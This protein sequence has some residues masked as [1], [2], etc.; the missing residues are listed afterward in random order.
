[1]TR[2]DDGRCQDEPDQLGSDADTEIMTTPE[3][4]GSLTSGNFAHL[5]EHEAAIDPFS[6][7]VSIRSPVHEDLTGLPSFEQFQPDRKAF[8]FTGNSFENSFGAARIESAM[9]GYEGSEQSTNQGKTSGTEEPKKDRSMPDSFSVT[10]NAAPQEI[11]IQADNTFRKG[12][13]SGPYDIGLTNP[14]SSLEAA[15]NTNKARSLGKTALTW[16]SSVS[17]AIGDELAA[18]HDHMEHCRNADCLQ[19]KA[20]FDGIQLPR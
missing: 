14:R 7:H 13:S 18:I 20:F 17:T 3:F 12:F 1:M 2:V 10:R 9:K 19:A 11:S 6:I 5:G 15:D 16:G 4:W 8:Q